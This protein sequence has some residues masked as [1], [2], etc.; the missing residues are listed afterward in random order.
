MKAFLIACYFLVHQVTA[1]ATQPEKESPPLKKI[2]IL[3]WNIYMLPHLVASHS[4]KKER[5]RVIGETLSDSDYD[6]IFFQEAF[7]ST[8]RNK[9][10]AQLQAKFPYH[11]GPANRKLF[12]IKANSGLWIFSKYPIDKIESIIY[13]NKFGIDALSRKGALLVELN[14]QGQRIQIA[15]THLQ[16]CGPVWLRQVQCVEF[17]ERLLKPNARDGVP[18][19]ICGDFNIDRYTTKEDYRFMLQA[20][21]AKDSNDETDQY[22]YDRISNDL[23]VEK[24]NRKDL[25]DYIL[26][27]SNGGLAICSNSVTPIKR[28]WSFKHSDLSDHYAIQAEINF[29]NLNL[30]TVA[31]AK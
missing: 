28:K 20:L 18:Q 23:H 1:A 19:I 4:D 12:S 10:L 8:A 11:A 26:F 22:S 3:S 30:S 15:G 31:L 13:K 14:V 2:K 27:R 21:D 17:Y 5:A 24:G 29:S 6:V 9:I 25:I 16:N 7:H